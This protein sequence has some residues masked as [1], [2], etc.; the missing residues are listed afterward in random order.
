MWHNCCHRVFFHFTRMIAGPIYVCKAWLCHAG[1]KLIID[2]PSLWSV[3]QLL[4]PP[5]SAMDVDFAFTKWYWS[6]K[7][8][9]QRPVCFFAT[10]NT[11][12]LCSKTDG[13][14]QQQGSAFNCSAL[15]QTNT[16]ENEEAGEGGGA[17]SAQGSWMTV[18]SHLKFNLYSC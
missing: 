7:V 13:A 8:V 5:H 10:A 4:L 18:Q 17:Q 16:T 9:A 1:S 6:I 15:H 14:A 3:L 11:A 12:T 2:F